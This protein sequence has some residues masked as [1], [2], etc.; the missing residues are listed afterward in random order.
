MEASPKIA[1]Q[2]VVPPDALIRMGRAL[3]A[4]DKGDKAVALVEQQLGANDASAVRAILSH[5]IPRWHGA[6]LHESARN[7]AFASAIAHAV[8]PDTRVLDIGAGSG[9][10]AMMAARAG[11]AEVIA[12]EAHKALARTAEGIVAANGLAGVVRV[13]GRNSR[14]LEADAD[15]GGRIDLVIS[16]T[17]SNDLVSEGALGTLRHAMQALAQPGARVIPRKASIRVAFGRY[18][19]DAVRPVADVHGFD[20]SRFDRHRAARFGVEIGDPRLGLCSPVTDLF[21]FDFEA[22]DW[23]LDEEVELEL[24]AGALAPNGVV[25]WIKLQLDEESGYENAPGPGRSSHWAALFTPFEAGVKVGPGGTVRIH[26]RHG[27]DDLRIWCSL[28]AP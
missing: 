27:E 22:G 19:G 2:A 26:G 20:L 15:L 17:F 8:R 13:I 10:L 18:D 23:Q 5:K 25:Q 14:E 3:M 1:T 12:C 6:M 7:D 4:S 9:L 16:E 24:A 11:A 28:T 21:A